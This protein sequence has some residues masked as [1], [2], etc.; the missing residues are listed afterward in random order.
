MEVSNQMKSH[1]LLRR[2]D[3]ILLIFTFI[4]IAI[5]ISVG[6][7][8]GGAS[9][10]GFDC[11]KNTLTPVEKIICSDPELAALDA[12]MSKLFEAKK[13]SIPEKERQSFFD[14]QRR[15]LKQR[16]SSCNIKNNAQV[17]G[18][19][20]EEKKTCLKN[21]YQTRINDLKTSDSDEWGLALNE[22]ANRIRTVHNKKRKEILYMSDLYSESSAALI[23]G[24][25]SLRER[26]Q[27]RRAASGEGED[28]GTGEEVIKAIKKRYILTESLISEISEFAKDV[29][30][31]SLYLED[32]DQDGIKDVI[33]RSGSGN[34]PFA[35]AAYLFYHGNRNKTLTKIE[36][37]DLDLSQDVIHFVHLNNKTYIALEYN[38]LYNKTEQPN[39]IIELFSLK[40]KSG[41]KGIGKIQIN[42]S[43]QIKGELVKGNNP[44]FHVLEEKADALVRYF[45]RKDPSPLATSLMNN[46]AWTYDGKD[47]GKISE[48]IG[49]EYYTANFQKNDSRYQLLDIDNDGK[50]EIVCYL[51][52]KSK[53]KYYNRMLVVKMG[54]SGPISYIDVDKYYPE[55]S[56]IDVKFHDYFCCNSFSGLED[57]GLE[58]EEGKGSEYFPLSDGKENYIVKIGI[59]LGEK[60]GM[61]VTNGY[62]LGIYK[63]KAGKIELVDAMDFDKE[64]A[65]K[66]VTVLK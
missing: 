16:D 65:F 28:I 56:H 34:G 11:Q 6:T 55:L 7:A 42:Y 32:V 60:Y 30:G 45:E 46:T 57:S 49:K 18:Q 48:L 50:K 63:L 24:P 21:L 27:Q 59:N 26:I 29:N 20:T 37:P 1:M 22:L 2:R 8:A 62:I 19:A 54:T 39:E 38:H 9:S 12:E 36:G 14:D 40:S 66:D 58:G 15:W 33:L 41:R 52:Y 35:E 47:A 10:P 4:F 53:H 64:F 43:S 23:E 17:I 51:V 13:K 5:P 3:F 61:P 31:V 25:A 44:A